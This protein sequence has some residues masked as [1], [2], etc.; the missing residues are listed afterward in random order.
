[1]YGCV[2]AVYTPGMTSLDTLWEIEF[3]SQTVS[4]LHTGS[5]PTCAPLGHVRAQGSFQAVHYLRLCCVLQLVTTYLPTTLINDLLL[6]QVCAVC[7]HDRERIMS[8]D[9]DSPD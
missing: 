3:I 9:F 4:S 2:Q 6:I 7:Q 8:F 1:M 5:I